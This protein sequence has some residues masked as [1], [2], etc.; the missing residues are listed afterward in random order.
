MGKKGGGGAPG[1]VHGVSGWLWA[2]DG[3]PPSLSTVLLMETGEGGSNGKR[4]KT[5][6]FLGM[7][8]LVEHPSVSARRQT[9]GP[10]RLGGSRSTAGRPTPR[11]VEDLTYTRHYLPTPSPLPRLGVSFLSRLP[12]SI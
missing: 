8:A 7:E 11:T 9:P 12:L 10:A 6:T 5:H 3:A 4:E 1:T 2:R